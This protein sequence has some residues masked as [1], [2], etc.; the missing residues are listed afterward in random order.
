MISPVNDNLSIS[1]QCALLSVSRSN[2]YYSPKGESNFDLELMQEI[3][4]QIMDTPFYGSRQM[5]RHLLRLGYKVGRRRVRTLMRK[6]GIEAIY[7][8]PKTSKSEPLHKKYPYL[9]TGLEITK[10]NQV[11]CW[12]ISP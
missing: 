11:W 8:K 10:P 4:K 1:R 5:M 7:Q 3:D 12:D 2:Y 6:M 9:L